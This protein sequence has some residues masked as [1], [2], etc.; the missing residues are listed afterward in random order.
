[1]AARLTVAGQVTPATAVI[2]YA[3]PAR[4][5]SSAA[6]PAVTNAKLIDPLTLHWHLH[7]SAGLAV[8][9]ALVLVLVL[10]VVLV[11]V[12]VLAVAPA[13]PV[14]VGRRR[15]VYASLL[16]VKCAKGTGCVARAEGTTSRIRL[17]ASRAAHLAPRGMLSI[18]A[19]RTRT[20]RRS[21]ATGH[22]RNAV[23]MCSPSALAAMCARTAATRHFN[24][25][26]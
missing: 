17:L 15:E 2:G 23:A 26:A 16:I 5:W 3:L 24:V 8:A 6:S 9:V 25:K 19:L 18:V 1:M 4:K 10:A 11:L 22:A 20:R 14:A 12:L 21:R 13:E 7:G